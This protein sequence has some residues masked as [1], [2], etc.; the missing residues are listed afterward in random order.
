MCSSRG[1][2]LSIPLS[3]ERAPAPPS[4]A[5]V[6]LSTKADSAPSGRGVARLRGPRPQQGRDRHRL[7]DERAQGP[8]RLGPAAGLQEEIRAPVPDRP[9]PP[10]P[11]PAR[12]RGRDRV[13]QPAARLGMGVCAGQGLGGPLRIAGRELEPP[14]RHH[15]SVGEVSALQRRPARASGTAIAGDAV[16]AGAAFGQA[17]VQQAVAQAFEPH[18][19]DD[20]PPAA[21]GADALA[22]VEQVARQYRVAVQPRDACGHQV[23]PNR[24]SIGATRRLTSKCS[25][26]MRAAS[27][28]RSCS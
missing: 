20:A 11:A 3:A 24:P 17:A 16:D 7:V 13:E 6:R 8:D 18:R 15:R 1:D 10:A 12:W 28:R 2:R 14:A 25:A 26:L 23:A 27:A 4:E 9:A 19:H 21:R 22:L 5:A